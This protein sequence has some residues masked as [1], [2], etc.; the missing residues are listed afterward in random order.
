MRVLVLL[1]NS[2]GG[3]VVNDDA[4]LVVDNLLHNVTLSGSVLQA[5]RPLNAIVALSVCPMLNLP[6]LRPGLLG[7]SFLST[8]VPHII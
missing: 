7:I 6:M 5:R 4:A 2:R 8:C 3:P 1:L